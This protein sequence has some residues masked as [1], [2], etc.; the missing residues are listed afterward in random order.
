MDEQKRQVAGQ[1]GRGEVRE[2]QTK[3]ADYHHDGGD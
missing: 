3:G 2:S 1:A